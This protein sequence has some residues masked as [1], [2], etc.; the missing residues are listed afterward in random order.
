LAGPLETGTSAALA[1]DI[2]AVTRE[3][4]SNCARHAGATTGGISLTLDDGVI[5]L[6][7]TDN[8]R[9]IGIPARSSGL[10]SMRH[11]AERN[12]GSLKLTTPPGGGTCLTWTATLRP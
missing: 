1:H 7:V 6:E 8:G 4:L 12:G 9:G 5:T 10:T 2:L 3:A 11:R